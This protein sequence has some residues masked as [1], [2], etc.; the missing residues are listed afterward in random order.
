LTVSI[1]TLMVEF[2]EET[3]LR[4]LMLNALTPHG[5]WKAAKTNIL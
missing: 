4:A 5:V 2:V 1:I 3:F